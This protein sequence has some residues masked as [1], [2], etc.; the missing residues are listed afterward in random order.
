M[1]TSHNWLVL[2]KLLYW[3]RHKGIP[4]PHTL[5]Q[6]LM[7]QIQSGKC[8]SDGWAKCEP[9]GWL[10]SLDMSCMQQCYAGV[11]WSLQVS[12]LFSGKSSTSF[13][14]EKRN[15]VTKSSFYNQNAILEHSNIHK[16]LTTNF[17]LK[18]IPQIKSDKQSQKNYAWIKIKICAS[19][20]SSWEAT[21][22]EVITW[23]DLMAEW[24]TRQQT[25]VMI[26]YEQRGKV[27]A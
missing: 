26:L 6:Q 4:V 9:F 12:C 25:T 10:A 17:Y 23:K 27:I 8:S 5:T 11:T 2:H 20:S 16:I 14:T 21:F 7:W 3:R 18:Y 22:T 1:L 24:K 15:T 19:N 13:L